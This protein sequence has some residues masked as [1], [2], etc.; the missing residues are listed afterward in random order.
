MNNIRQKNVIQQFT[1]NSEMPYGDFEYVDHAAVNYT[2]DSTDINHCMQT[3]LDNDLYIEQSLN[4]ASAY[5]IGPKSYDESEL[6]YKPNGYKIWGDVATADCLDVRQKIETDLKDTTHKSANF[7][8][9]KITFVKAFDN[10]VFVGSKTGPVKYSTDVEHDEWH[11]LDVSITANGCYADNT[12]MLFAAE[13]GVYELS[14]YMNI[15]TSDE[16]KYGKKEYSAVRLNKNTLNHVTAVGYNNHR[17]MVTVATSSSTNKGRV[18]EAPYYASSLL[19]DR[20]RALDFKECH[21]FDDKSKVTPC[22]NDVNVAPDKKTVLASATGILTNTMRWQFTD[23]I[24]SNPQNDGNEIFK[25]GLA[26]DEFLFFGSNKGLYRLDPSTEQL[27]KILSNYDIQ[28]M[29][30]DKNI[31]FVSCI[32]KNEF[33][34]TIKLVAIK[35][36]GTLI[37]GDVLSMA[38]RNDAG[39][40]LFTHGVFPKKN[41][42]LLASTT[43]DSLEFW[44]ISYLIQGSLTLFCITQLDTPPALAAGI[45]DMCKIG[46]NIVFATTSKIYTFSTNVW[47]RNDSNLIKEFD[48]WGYGS[49]VY[50]GNV[51]KIVKKS[52]RTQYFVSDGVIEQIAKPTRRISLPTITDVVYTTIGGYE[53]LVATCGQQMNFVRIDFNSL[54]LENTLV[55][56]SN[57]GNIIVDQ[58]NVISRTADKLYWVS[59]ERPIAEE[60]RLM[61]SPINTYISQLASDNVTGYALSGSSIN[62][63]EN[64]IY[65][66]KSY[67]ILNASG[68]LAGYSVQELTIDPFTNVYLMIGTP[69]SSNISGVYAL[70][71]FEDEYGNI[72]SAYKKINNA[73]KGT[74]QICIITTS[75]GNRQIATIDDADDG[76]GF[77]VRYVS[78][79]MKEL[80]KYSTNLNLWSSIVMQ[81]LTTKFTPTS[82]CHGQ[83]NETECI[84]VT[85]HD[86]DS[87]HQTLYKITPSM[88]PKNIDELPNG[89]RS[90]ARIEFYLN[91]TNDDKFSTF[92]YIQTNTGKAVV[93]QHQTESSIKTFSQLSSGL[94]ATYASRLATYFIKES[95]GKVYAYHYDDVAGDTSIGR[96]AN[97]DEISCDGSVLTEIQEIVQ[98]DIQTQDPKPEGTFNLWSDVTFFIGKRKVYL[99]NWDKFDLG[100]EDSGD[101][102]F[103]AT[104]VESFETQYDIQ[105][106]NIQKI[107]NPLMLVATTNA[108]YFNKLMD[109]GSIIDGEFTIPCDTSFTALSSR[110]Y[111]INIDDL[112]ASNGCLIKNAYFVMDDKIDVLF[113]DK[114]IVRYGINY[115]NQNDRID[116][117]NFSIYYISTIAVDA[118]ALIQCQCDLAYFT[119]MARPDPNNTVNNKLINVLD[120]STFDRTIS[121]PHSGTANEFYQLYGEY[122]INDTN[123]YFVQM[124]L[125]TKSD[126]THIAIDDAKPT[127]LPLH[128]IKL[129]IQHTSAASHYLFVI[130]ANKDLYVISDIEIDTYKIK[131]IASNILTV[132]SCVVAY[133]YVDVY[134]VDSNNDMYMHRYSTS[135]DATDFISITSVDLICSSPKDGN[136]NKV[137]INQILQLEANLHSNHVFGITNDEYPIFSSSESTDVY[138]H[139]GKYDVV[140]SDRPANDNKAKLITYVPFYGACYVITTTSRY[141]TTSNL[142]LISNNFDI[143]STTIGEITQVFAS[144]TLILCKIVSGATTSWYYTAN[145][146]IIDDEKPRPM[147]LVSLD[148]INH[149]LAFTCLGYFNNINVFG[150]TSGAKH[151]SYMDIYDLSVSNMHSVSQ[152]HVQ[153]LNADETRGKIG[154]IIKNRYT[155]LKWYSPKNNTLEDS[156]FKIKIDFIGDTQTRTQNDLP[157]L[158]TWS[159][160]YDV[161]LTNASFAGKMADNAFYCE[162]DQSLSSTILHDLESYKGKQFNDYV[163]CSISSMEFCHYCWPKVGENMLKHYANVYY[164]EM[165]NSYVS[166]SRT[167]I[168]D[169]N[170]ISSFT[171][172]DYRPA[173]ETELGTKDINCFSITKDNNCLWIA[174][175]DSILKYDYNLYAIRKMPTNRI[176]LAQYDSPMTYRVISDGRMLS[177]KN[178]KIWKTMFNLSSMSPSKISSVNDMENIDVH[179]YLYGTDSGLFYSKYDY[180]LEQ[181]VKAFT[182]ESA[183]ALYDQVLTA[184]NGICSQLCTTLSDHLSTEHISSAVI[185]KLNAKYLDVDMQ[186]IENWQTATVDDNSMVV[187]NDIIQEMFFGSFL[188][189]DVVASCNNYLNDKSNSAFEISGLNYIMKRWMSGLTELYIHLPTTY[190]YYLP[191]Q[192]G[193]GNCKSNSEISYI[194]KNLADYGEDKMEQGSAMSSHYTTI[195]IGITSSEYHI[196]AL[197]EIQINGNSLPL[198][199]Y[200]DSSNNSQL[201]ANTLYK[202]FV[203]PSVVKTYDI[204][205]TNEDGYYIF[206]FGCFGTDSQSIKLVFYDNSARS[207]QSWI[208]INFDPNGGSGVMAKQKFILKEDGT[209]ECKTLKKNKF[210][211]TDGTTTKIFNGWTITPYPDDYIWNGTS[212]DGTQQYKDGTVFPHGETLSALEQELGRDFAIDPLYRKEEITLYASWIS[213]EFTTADTTFIMNSN[214]TQFYIADV[215]IDESTKLKDAVVIAFGE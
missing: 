110:L 105:N 122:T 175:D 181:D 190:T 41:I 35:P 177:S 164:N 22:V 192:W 188:D 149:G 201:T 150:T 180:V 49:R 62:N 72:S 78:V 18:Y 75:F 29:F 67:R 98:Y 116:S 36:D 47:K 7:G 30:G 134:V 21:M 44:K 119:Y 32:D 117:S 141:S 101:P 74:K 143:I 82:I 124:H 138:I 147:R 38:F 108:L 131:K 96:Q 153:S 46:R 193:A 144:D 99:K 159:T 94:R 61:H 115:N 42:A 33:F 212:Y 120:Y 43:N 167:Q 59:R 156:T 65:E 88:T 109:D 39:H 178:G 111:S 130:D 48:Q 107:K 112:P 172:Y 162:I 104:A 154:T 161:K 208:K 55:A 207:N 136:E 203:E 171:G 58:H 185:S 213:Y 2:I 34:P 11:T 179:T 19:A 95:D 198:A 4:S 60:S 81:D 26:I 209:L 93:K 68:A 90:V 71:V 151:P 210:V 204:T 91:D 142:R 191:N 40:R 5:M 100:S 145:Y 80:P 160:E 84:Y 118:R 92:V 54:T 113:N 214:K 77:G 45:V 106:A 25:T 28:C 10:A 83:F 79:K 152:S 13:D 24:V 215:G 125:L 73:K 158:S 186:D 170:G 168:V 176:C 27:D 205:K 133:G 9:S 23:L 140:L 139:N 202:S 20:Q 69:P 114:R 135:L 163:S 86:G 174:T 50:T 57:L 184:P 199:I 14:T 53:Y 52:N 189:G 200:Q 17:S 194:R 87:S 37:S 70:S 182:H 85:G 64:D 97:L 157:N 146:G 165:S 66:I 12:R 76:K 127:C 155:A 63:A 132:Y 8:S 148:T 126:T 102:E 169:V 129:N 183:L 15:D 103:N 6:T 137:P 195:Q 128:D 31:V 51:K 89:I 3:L 211:N 187:R 1:N 197:H 123:D 16:T 121:T 173:F 196:D 56:D 206:N 166:T